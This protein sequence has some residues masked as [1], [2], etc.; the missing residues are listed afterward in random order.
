LARVHKLT[1]GDDYKDYVQD[2]VADEYQG[3]RN[4]WVL[5]TF[6][7]D[8]E[9][10]AEYKKG[11]LIKQLTKFNA[12]YDNF[13]TDDTFLSVSAK[14]GQ[15]LWGNAAIY[16]LLRDH[17][18][19]NYITMEDLAEYPRLSSMFAA[20]EAIPAVKEWLDALKAKED[21]KKINE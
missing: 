18:L 4:Q 19:T 3:F 5:V 11:G 9:D 21:E 2:L 7:G 17:I 12:L 20:Y 16:G 14:T 15:S 8:D 13:K 6:S 10:K 1:S